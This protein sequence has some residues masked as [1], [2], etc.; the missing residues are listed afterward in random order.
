MLILKTVLKALVAIFL[1]ASVF[2]IPEKMYY[3]LNSDKITDELMR[4]REKYYSGVINVWQ[5]DCFEGGTGS[6]ANWLKGITA[7]FERKNNGV[8]VNVEAYSIEMAQKLIKS[9]QKKPDM[10]SFGAGFEIDRSMLLSLEADIPE[11]MGEIYPEAVPWCMGA[12]FMLGDGD[13]S[14]WGI[15]GKTVTSKK[16][17]YTVFSVG[18][19]QKYGYNALEALSKNCNN[20]FNDEKS[21]FTGTPQDVFEAYNYSQKL[22]RMIGTQRDFYRLAAAE[23]KERARKGEIRYLGYSDLFQY[24]SILKCDDQKKIYAMNGFVSYLLTNECQDKLGSIG[25]F[26]VVLNS[27]PQYDNSYASSGWKSIVNEGILCTSYLFEVENAAEEQKNTLE[28]L[29]KQ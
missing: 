7:G 28:K 16:S 21:L 1:V 10:I 24:V 29:Q 17:T 8:Y 19:P 18:Y 13:N 14:L 11:V 12:Y 9:G 23:S 3:G 20:T 6:R 25:M 26:P 22:N 15:D 4:R 2:L 5:I 27:Q